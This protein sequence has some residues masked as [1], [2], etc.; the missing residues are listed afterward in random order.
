MLVRQELVHIVTRP[1]PDR[2]ECSNPMD[3]SGPDSPPVSSPPPCAAETNPWAQALQESMDAWDASDLD[4]ED[5]ATDGVAQPRP[6]PISAREVVLPGT[7]FEHNPE[8]GVTLVSHRIVRR[9]PTR[10]EVEHRGP[11]P[12]AEA[13]RE[14]GYRA[15]RARTPVAFQE[16]WRAPF[17][18]PVLPVCHSCVRDAVLADS[19]SGTLWKR[20]FNAPDAT[21]ATYDLCVRH[22]FLLEVA[23]HPTLQDRWRVL[24]VL[25]EFGVR[26]QRT[27]AMTA[28]VAPPETRIASS[29]RQSLH[30][31]LAANAAKWSVC[32]TCASINRRRDDVMS[33]STIECA[34][35]GLRA[36]TQARITKQRRAHIDLAW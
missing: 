13:Q 28:T 17:D 16:Q 34:N 24:L 23:P 30:D 3:V 18:H 15:R 26:R 12:P 4:A 6:P 1:F 29:L 32:S 22:A 21:E 27:H 20:A 7:T 35:N 8:T 11:L 36:F 5:D 31:A 10:A 25:S 2:L 14:F 19:K 33:C 9:A